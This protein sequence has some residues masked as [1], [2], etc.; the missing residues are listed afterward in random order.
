[1]MNCLFCEIA[2]GNIDSY[3][4]YEDDIVKCFLDINPRENGHLLI[5][6]KQHF[7]DL[8]DIDEKTMVYLFKIS[9]KMKKLLEER[10]QCDGVMIMQNNGSLQE[11]KHFHLHLVPDYKNAKKNIPI[12]VIYDVLV[13]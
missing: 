11:I 8:D 3:T 13:K 7:L 4:I 5:I 6:P 2:M 9:I 1:M 10:L 12:D